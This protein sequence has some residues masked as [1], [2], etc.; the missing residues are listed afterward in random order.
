M[1]PQVVTVAQRA[2]HELANDR[3]WVPR[4]LAVNGA[5]VA[6]AVRGCGGRDGR[7]RADHHARPRAR[8]ARGRPEEIAAV[9]AFLASPAAS[10]ITGPALDVDGGDNA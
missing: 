1:L 7:R 8:H 2:V 10:H 9:I 6:A 4:Q 3:P 5:G